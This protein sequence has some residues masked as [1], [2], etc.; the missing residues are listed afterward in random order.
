MRPATGAAMRVYDSCSLALST[1][2]WSIFTV[3][4]SCFTS[5]ACWSTCCDAIESWLRSV[6]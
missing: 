6:R 4:S 3:P 5:E 2:A 1:W